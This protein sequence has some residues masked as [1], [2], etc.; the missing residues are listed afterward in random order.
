MQVIEKALEIEGDMLENM[1]NGARETPNFKRPR[2]Q[3]PSNWRAPNLRIGGGMG[4][5]VIPAQRNV[6]LGWG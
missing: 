2:Y 5:R 1:E 4:S 3:G 6:N